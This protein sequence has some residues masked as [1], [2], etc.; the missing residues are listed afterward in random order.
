MP[1]CT[2]VEWE[3]GFALA[4]W[5]AMVGRSGVLDTLPPGCLRRVVGVTADDGLCVIEMWRSG[6]DARAFAEAS[7]PNLADFEVP[8]PDHVVGFETAYDQT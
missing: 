3:R 6:D 2:I 7:A 1:F 4:D 8:P 5:E